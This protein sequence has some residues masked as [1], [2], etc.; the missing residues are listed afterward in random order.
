MPEEVHVAGIVVHAAPERIDAVRRAVEAIDGTEIHV[1]GN[2]KL[3]VTVEAGN[4][5]DLAERVTE[6]GRL[7]GVLAAAPVY[8]HAETMEDPPCSPA[9]M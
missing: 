9:A 5:V 7:D 6:I 1:E 8:H 3:V 4:A 2:G